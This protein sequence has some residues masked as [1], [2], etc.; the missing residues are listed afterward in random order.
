MLPSTG[1]LDHQ[2]QAFHAQDGDAVTSSEKYFR[3]KRH[4]FTSSTVRFVC[5]SQIRPCLAGTDW[6]PD[7][8][9]DLQTRRAWC[10]TLTQKLFLLLQR[11][12]V[13]NF[14]EELD[15]G[16]VRPVLPFVFST[17]RSQDHIISNSHLPDTNVMTLNYC[18]LKYN[19]IK[20]L[21]CFQ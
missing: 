1:G 17:L 20:K 2:L 5:S 9:W 13:E 10:A 21:K 14:P 4:G 16:M 7:K 6:G 15:G 19:S 3:D 12:T 8:I 18:F 11:K